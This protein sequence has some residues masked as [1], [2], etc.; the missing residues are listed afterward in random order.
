MPLPNGIGF[1]L[2]GVTD[3]EQAGLVNADRLFHNFARGAAETTL[4]SRHKAHLRRA[5][6]WTL[7]H[8]AIAVIEQV[9]LRAVQ[10]RVSSLENVCDV[11]IEC[12]SDISTCEYRP[13]RCR[14]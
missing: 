4:S 3:V 6:L 8:E 13:G 7:M 12:S 2:K 5:A 11:G 9:Q 1:D 14:D 10:M